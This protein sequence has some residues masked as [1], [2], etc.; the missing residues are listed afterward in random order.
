MGLL[1]KITGSVT[2]KFV[3]LIAAAVFSALLWSHKIWWN[4]CKSLLL[5]NFQADRLADAVIFLSAFFLVF[6]CYLGVVF[7]R[8]RRKKKYKFNSN[9][10]ILYG[11]DNEKYCGSCYHGI[12]RSRLSRLQKHKDG[13]WVCSSSVCGEDYR[14]EGESEGEEPYEKPLLKDLL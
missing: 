6:F 14:P 7:L 2:S 13:I 3:E 1:K 4:S 5:E 10:G 12:L 8:N 11:P 9:D